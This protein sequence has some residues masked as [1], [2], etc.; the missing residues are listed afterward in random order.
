MAEKSTTI[1]VGTNPL[2]LEWPQDQYGITSMLKK[3]GVRAVG[4]LNGDD[5]KLDVF[6][7]TVRLL[8]QYA[9]EKHAEQTRV[10]A[11]RATEV[12]DYQRVDRERAE[13]MR[14]SSIARLQTELGRLTGAES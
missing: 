3:E 6:L 8:V 12:A 4:R 1:K 14:Q 10:N 7:G 9:K 11:A 2:N 5:T 13:A